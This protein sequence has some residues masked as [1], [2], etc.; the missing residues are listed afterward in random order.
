MLH[1]QT[2]GGGKCHGERVLS[3]RL[4]IAT[5]V[6][7]HWHT[8][9]EFAQR[10]EVHAS[11]HELDQPRAAQLLWADIVAKSLNRSLR[12]N[13]RNNRLWTDDSSNQKMGVDGPVWKYFFSHRC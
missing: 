13:S 4:G 12:A 3:H 9:R 5:A 2:L 1:D 7:C 11:D 10:N 8:L 6:G